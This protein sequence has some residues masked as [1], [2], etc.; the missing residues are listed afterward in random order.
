MDIDNYFNIG[1]QY[2]Y[3]VLYVLFILD[4]TNSVGITELNII[5][6]VFV[7]VWRRK[8]G[9]HFEKCFYSGV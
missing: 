2:V 7:F 6:D 3:T 8:K 4:W 5:V 1:E 9:S